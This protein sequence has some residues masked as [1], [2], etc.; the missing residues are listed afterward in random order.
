MQFIQPE[1][2]MRPYRWSQ[3]YSLLSTFTP[4]LE[5]VS[6]ILQKLIYVLGSTIY[7]D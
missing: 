2:L 1:V 3:N 7:L 4:S 5:M 6:K